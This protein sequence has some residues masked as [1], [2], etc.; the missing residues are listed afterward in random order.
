MASPADLL[1][2]HVNVEITAEALSTIV[3]NA[4]QV[5]GKDEKGGYRV[6]TAAKVGE[7]ISRFL[8]ANDFERFV[9]NIQNYSSG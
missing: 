1:D 7:M 4:K 6:D 8:A 5:A 9:K 2:V 3:E